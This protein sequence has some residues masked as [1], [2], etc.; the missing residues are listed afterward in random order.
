MAKLTGKVAVV[1]G[2]SKGIGAA[3]AKALAAEGAQVVVNYAS[4]KA[5]ADAVVQAIDAAGGKAIAVQGDVS[6]AE[7]AQGVVDAAINEFGKLDVLVNNSGV[8]EFAPIGEVT[9]EHYRRMFDVNVLGV[10]LTTQA[11]AKHLGEG[12]SVINISSVV[13]SLGL[14]ASA[15]YTGTKGAVE[16]INSV[17]A[18][19]LGPRKIRVNAILPGMVETE[20]AHSAG[21]IGS[22]LQQTM[23]AQTPLGRIGQPDDIADIAVFL[24][25]DDARWLTGERLV[26]SGGF[27]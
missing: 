26:A 20:G 27:R 17:L 21:V 13:T 1:T 22:D 5:G 6:K 16:G 24:A 18:K 12:G 7:Q 2:A 14:P 23:V 8:Y 19:E 11:A 3:I 15:V 4:S 25:S 9:E 10:L